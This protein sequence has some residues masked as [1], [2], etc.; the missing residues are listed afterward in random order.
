MNIYR[1]IQLAAAAVT[2][3]GALVLGLLSSSSAL[4]ATCNG[5][6]YCFNQGNFCAFNFTNFCK[7]H[8]LP[9]CTYSSYYCISPTNFCPPAGTQVIC[10]YH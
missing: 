2:A 3:N 9:G 7:G 1:K 10:L 4:A 6:T 8:T 5:Q